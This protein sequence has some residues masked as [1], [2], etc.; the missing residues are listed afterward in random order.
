[1]TNKTQITQVTRLII[2]DNKSHQD[3]GDVIIHIKKKL[4]VY[5]IP[6]IY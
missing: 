3:F 2:S 1:M 6:T 5:S 4:K